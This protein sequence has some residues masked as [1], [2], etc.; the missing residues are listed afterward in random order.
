MTTRDFAAYSI[1]AAR[2]TGELMSTRLLLALKNLKGDPVA[3]FKN[4]GLHCAL[5]QFLRDQIHVASAQTLIRIC[6]L[7][8]AQL[9]GIAAERDGRPNF[10]SED[11]PLLFYCLISA[12]SLREAIQRG[13]EF[14]RAIDGRCG[15]MRLH[16][17]GDTAEIQFSCA[18]L[19]RSMA[20]FF[21]DMFGIAN[22]HGI[23]SWLIA[24]PLPISEVLMN[25]GN[26]MRS[27]LDRD[28]LP[29]PVHLDATISGF[30]FPAQFL[31][32][33]IM[34]T[35]ED[36]DARVSFSFIFNMPEENSQ[37]AFAER[38][39]RLMHRMLR[40]NN[41]PPSLQELSEKFGLSQGT[42]RRYLK[43][44][45]MSYNQIKDSCR[46]ELA[47][48]LLQR[49]SLSIEEISDRLGFCDSDAF[50]RA[51]HQWLDISPSQYRKRGTADPYNRLATEA[52]ER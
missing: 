51:F 41:F 9:A 20:S 50:R 21:V 48:N 4:V 5:E 28:V 49:S 40:E 13:G 11:W 47:L 22:M 30:R 37:L 14:F 27:Y 33:P 36:C 34:R 15:F 2:E 43:A 12:R 6:A 35:N 26:E 3:I 38:A 46:R 19:Q 31:D 17:E 44:V 18:Y 7:S 45:G 52:A 23:F 10:R 24:Q 42:F 29:F 39:R 25:Y 32:F 1:L 8:A 16:E